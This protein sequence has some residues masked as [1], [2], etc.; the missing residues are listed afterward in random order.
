MS[1]AVEKKKE[2]ERKH[3]HTKLFYMGPYILAF[4]T[5]R[6]QP[7]EQS[8][9]SSG[10]PHSPSDNQKITLFIPCCVAT[11]GNG[12]ADGHKQ[13]KTTPKRHEALPCKVI[14]IQWHS[15]YKASS[16]GLK[17]HQDVQNKMN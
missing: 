12:H 17:F 8:L 14:P 9:R 5:L 11:G 2:K 10:D 13:K 3:T 1:M 16:N 4:A 6:G 7:L 15:S